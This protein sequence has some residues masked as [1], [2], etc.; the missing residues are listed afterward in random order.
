MN[1]RPPPNEFV[2]SFRNDQTDFSVAEK[3]Q[4]ED[5]YYTSGDLRINLERPMYFPPEDGRWEVA[6]VSV[7][8]PVLA[9]N[10]FPYGRFMI[11]GSILGKPVFTVYLDV[12]LVTSA[13]DLVK[14]ITAAFLGTPAEKQVKFTTNVQNKRVSISLP[15]KTKKS[16]SYIVLTPELLLLCGFPT[17]K[18]IFTNRTTKRV[19]FSAAREAQVF[20]SKSHTYLEMDG[21][22]PLVDIGSS[23][24]AACPHDDEKSELDIGKFI[25]S[26]NRLDGISTSELEANKIRMYRFAPEFL[27][28]SMLDLSTYHSFHFRF[29][30]SNGDDL[31]FYSWNLP[32]QI[33]LKFRKSNLW[34]LY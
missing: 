10:L 23:I 27:K 20:A 6:V 2:V 9:L 34:N 5:D 33:C 26:F 7:E 14:T 13:K 25:A 21:T 1:S 11:F 18:N 3:H 32:I 17:T 16:A 22:K 15:A 31:A 19:T 24:C 8:C 29:L 4:H 28:Y 30:D 12:G